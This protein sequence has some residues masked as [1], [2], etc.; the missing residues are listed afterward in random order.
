MNS[1]A[2]R[3]LLVLCVLY[4]GPNL[5]Q[6]QISEQV[7]QSVVRIV[8]LGRDPQNPNAISGEEFTL[9][10][11]AH[12]Y[13][14]TWSMGTGFII[15]QLGYIITN[16]HV[17]APSDDSESTEH[18]YLIFVLQ[19]VS[20]H[21]T[22]YPATVIRQDPNA[23][24]AIIRCPELHGEPLQLLFSPV[25]AGDEVFSAGF[26][27]I[28][29]KAVRDTERDSKIQQ[30]FIDEYGNQVLEYY[31]QRFVQEQGRNPTDAEMEL[32]KNKLF[33]DI[34]HESP[35]RD[36]FLHALATAGTEHPSG[37]A[38]IAD[39]FEQNPLWKD[40]LEPT[41]TKGNVEKTFPMRSYVRGSSLSFAAIQHSCN[42]RHG[43]SGGPLLNGGG[44]VVGIVGRAYQEEES[45]VLATAIGEAK[46]LLDS[47]EIKYVTASP[48]HPGSPF[49]FALIAGTSAAALVAIAALILG[50]AALR[51]SPQGSM[52]KMID[53]LKQ[54]GMVLS[55]RV[56]PPTSVSWQ[57]VGRASTGK[58]FQL[59]LTGSMFDKNSK[60]LVLGRAR[61][62]CNLVVDDETVSRQHAQIRLTR[63]GFTVAD[64]NSSNGTAVNGQFSRRPFEELPFKVGDT[65]TL[66]EVK[67]DF[68][69]A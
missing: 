29:D 33:D 42:I 17:V 37:S 6:A 39:I 7:K 64:R 50:F 23:D 55:R 19:K 27:G 8:C 48:W 20:S 28:A 31:R 24:I 46:K 69:Q 13:L 9:K 66:G 3:L 25:Q 1:A 2:L 63:S 44:Q 56:I 58:T 18:P 60:R 54:R 49:S 4:S 62:L 43:N 57:L 32:L 36:E 61:D 15:N 16:N 52:T 11:G 22:L 14:Y 12:L 35:E 40:Y 47:S 38:D 10:S 65:L 51:K 59:T 26:P 21:A 34:S 5:L 30:E 68:R 41:I 53:D 45:V 67:L